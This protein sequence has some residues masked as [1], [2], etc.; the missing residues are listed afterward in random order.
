MVS[1]HP[2]LLSIL[3]TPEQDDD[4]EF[5][6]AQPPR[7]SPTPEEEEAKEE[8]ESKEPTPP[9]SDTKPPATTE[10]EAEAEATEPPRRRRG[11]R[12]VMRKVHVKDEDGYLCTREEAVWESY[13]EDEPESQPPAKQQRTAVVRT[14]PKME[15]DT[16]EGEAK[17]GK[18]PAAKKRGKAGAGQQGNIMSFFQ[19]K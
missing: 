13:S 15:T 12:K 9:A 2:S 11:K 8:P 6:S 7:K 18:K 10:A 16:D 5:T 19:K 3:L 4:E 14:K 17:G 1:S